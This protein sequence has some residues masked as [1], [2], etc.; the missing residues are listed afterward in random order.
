MRH[1]LLAVTI[2]IA[3]AIV[4]A[5]GLSIRAWDGGSDGTGHYKA[6]YVRDPV[7]HCKLNAQEPHIRAQKLVLADG[8]VQTFWGWVVWDCDNDTHVVID[9]NEEQ[10]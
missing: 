6:R 9:D 3:A 7:H 10:P 2:I 4:L 8:S 1:V 5:I